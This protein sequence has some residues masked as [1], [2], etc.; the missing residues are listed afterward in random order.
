MEALTG[1][2]LLVALVVLVAIAELFNIAAKTLQNIKAVR[3]PSKELAD[4]VDA[5]QRMLD[6][7]KKRL[8]SMEEGQNALCTAMLAILDHEISGNSTDKLQSA[9]TGLTNYLIKR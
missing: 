8:D 3:N 5:H 7:D 1:N 6:T 4:R 9:K 2:N